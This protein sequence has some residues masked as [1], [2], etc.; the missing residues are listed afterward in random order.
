[1]SGTYYIKY[2]LQKFVFYCSTTICV[3]VIRY[4][5]KEKPICVYEGWYIRLLP[6]MET[7]EEPC[8]LESIQED[9]Y[10]L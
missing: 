5:Y 6:A 8:L 3:Y 9:N 2:D 7:E 4:I 1:M 10:T